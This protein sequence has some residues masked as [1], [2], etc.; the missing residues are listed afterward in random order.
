MSVK[1]SDEVL[2]EIFIAHRAQLRRI[3][4]RIVGTAELADEI[5]QE[6][7][8]KVAHGA[9]SRQVDKPYCYCCQVVR[10]LA[11]DHCRR[12][13]VEATY[14][15]YTEDGELPHVPCASTPERVLHERRLLMSVEK[16]LQRLPQRTRHA[17]ELYRLSGL[18]QREIGRQLG[19]SA[20][21]VNFMLKDAVEALAGCREM[22][23]ES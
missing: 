18:T 10:N 19:C 4:L 15:V 8:L 7:Y 20:T 5:T 21:L 14:R 11:R 17:F 23:D 13:A 9:C 22:R 1:L 6:A 2:A 12:Q 16:A 3:A